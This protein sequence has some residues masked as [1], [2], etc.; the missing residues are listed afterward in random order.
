MSNRAV[1]ILAKSSNPIPSEQSAAKTVILSS[2]SVE[3]KETAGE[4]QN[5]LA[6][7][8]SLLGKHLQVVSTTKV[9]KS[10]RKRNYYKLIDGGFNFVFDF[11]REN[12]LLSDSNSPTSTSQSFC[13][14]SAVGLDGVGKSSLL[15]R[16]ANQSIFPAHCNNPCQENPLTHITTGL[17][18]H[19]T[20][21]RMFLLDSQPLLSASI[22]SELLRTNSIQS[23]G[24]DQFAKYH[25]YTPSMSSVVGFEIAEPENFAF[26]YSLQL[27]T[28]LI[29][30]SDHLILV[31]DSF[32]LDAYLFKLLASSLMMVGDNAVSKANIVV[33]LKRGTTNGGEA[34]GSDLPTGEH[35][36]H[37]ESKLKETLQILLGP[38]VLFINN[39]EP[40]LLTT[41]LKPPSRN[42]VSEQATTI[43]YQT[44]KGWLQ[45]AQRY[46]DNSI[47]K[48]TLFL[49]YAKLMP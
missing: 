5:R 8:V 37:L 38:N 46:W 24:G 34:Y 40:L 47:R 6:K 19:I 7:P 44:E 1:K 31:I 16:I 15:N 22:L 36:F 21:E 28:Y 3:S 48:S 33:Y 32:S 35:Y 49:E 43:N 27:L 11:A 2:A 9:E 4:R 41:V 30:I 26:I 45:S 10:D 25:H 39:D 23:L 14:V 12:I 18:L 29:A 13:I 17:D 20:N 42:L